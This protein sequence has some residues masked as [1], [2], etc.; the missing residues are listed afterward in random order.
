ML[1]NIFFLAVSL[2][3][4]AFA[5][6]MCKGISL[7]RFNLQYCLT[8][9]TFFGG[10]QAIMPIIGW[11]LSKG[12]SDYIRNYDHWLAFLLLFLLGGKMVYD[13]F[14]DDTII[15]DKNV[16]SIREL[17]ILAIAT[18][19]DALAVGITL[20]VLSVNIFTASAIIGVVAF[21]L[22][23]VGV[24]IGGKVGVKYKSK[25]TLFGGIVLLI[26]SLKILLEHLK[27]I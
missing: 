25:A 7:K 8:I 17:F 11:L 1:G 6:A 10:F 19:I 16:L 23:S 21:V 12:F 2:S 13:S 20:T 18:S 24:I 22:S 4:D 5:I 15:P 26:M 9:A 27:I 3:M 14:R